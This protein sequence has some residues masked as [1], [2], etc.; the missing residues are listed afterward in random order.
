MPPSR[1]LISTSFDVLLGDVSLISVL[2]SSF[3]TTTARRSRA[4]F[5]I[6]QLV[7]NSGT[8]L[9][10]P[11]VAEF[12]GSPEKFRGSSP[13]PLLR[14]SSGCTEGKS[15]FLLRVVIRSF[16]FLG[17]LDEATF[18]DRC[19]SLVYFTLPSLPF[20]VVGV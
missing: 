9:V 18:G 14:R 2:S 5:M 16:Y 4:W 11:P 3:F 12:L 6:C 7:F 1:F 8:F 19:L 15:S 10:W 20:L 17:F 13:F